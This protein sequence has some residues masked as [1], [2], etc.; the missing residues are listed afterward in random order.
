M[1]VSI[2]SISIIGLG[3]MGRAMARVY[4]AAGYSVTVWNRTTSKAEALAKEGA[5]RAKTV[6][7]ALNASKLIILSLTEYDIMYKVLN[8]TTDALKDRALVNLS[9]DTPQKVR[10]AEKWIQDHNAEFLS[11]GVM[12][13]PPLVGKPEAYIFYSGS[14]AVY[15]AHE[16][17]LAVLGKPDY[18]GRDAGLSQL[19]YQ[20]L[21]NILY[22]SA[23]SVLHS[24]AMV[25]A[26]GV[27]AKVFEPYMMDFLDVLPYFF[28][29]LAKEVD[30]QQ[31]P[32]G[33]N[34]MTMMTAGA[35]HVVQTAKETNVD[36]SL[37]DLIKRIYDR[38]VEHGRGSDGLT[39][40]IEVLKKSV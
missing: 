38:T 8:G 6:A 17:T 39:S 26:A 28:K 20:A 1:S 18:R 33:E 2:N 12:V 13:D 19:Y 11:G 35:A 32:G 23:T 25:N 4:L 22:T 15:D 31:Y 5:V 3:P 14:R 7:D 40:I 29:D 27:S 21:L 30:T 24:M 16:Q 9:S 37:P 36:T 10:E 34:N